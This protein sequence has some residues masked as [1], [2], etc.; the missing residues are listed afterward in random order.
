MI[1]PSTQRVKS[2]SACVRACLSLHQSLFIVCNCHS[3]CCCCCCCWHLA[4]RC[5]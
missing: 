4:A 3:C 5:H 1:V 2:V